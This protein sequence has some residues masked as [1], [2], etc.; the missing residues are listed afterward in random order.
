[1]S[2]YQRIRRLHPWKPQVKPGKD[3]LPLRIPQYA[4]SPGWMV[5]SHESDGRPCAM[6]V[7][8]RDKATPVS[9]VMD[10]RMCSDTVIRV[11]RLSSDVY[12]ACDIRTL[13]GKDLIDTKSYAERR[14]LLDTLLEEFHTPDLSVLLTYDE[15][16]PLTSIRGWET[17]DD[18][19]GT[20]GVFLPAE[21]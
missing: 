6:F 12:V 13:N 20:L 14:A 8:A 16:P 2:S 1:M 7:D 4:G 21:E 17:Y 9:I 10:E 15:V 11:T 5:L 3:P 18:Q 19:P